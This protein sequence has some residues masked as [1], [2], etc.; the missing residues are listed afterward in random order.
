MST[1]ASTSAVSND[2]GANTA[3]NDTPPGNNNQIIVAEDVLRDLA[4]FN[5]PDR[6]INNY[7]PWAYRIRTTL[8][9]K[10]LGAAITD[11]N[12]A[13]TNPAKDASAH[14]MIIAN[15][16]FSVYDVIAETETAKQAWDVLRNNSQN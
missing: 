15:L 8:K 13:A 14:S 11:D 5:G 1:P 6:A 4:P 12:F 10:G 16:D 9:A 7:L 2:T 3:V